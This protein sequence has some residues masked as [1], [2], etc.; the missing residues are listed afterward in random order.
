MPTIT[1]RG[2]GCSCEDLRGLGDCGDQ[3]STGD[4]AAYSDWQACINN[5]AGNASANAAYV[6]QVVKPVTCP[7]GFHWDGLSSLLS[8]GLGACIK[9]VPADPAIYGPV[10]GVMVTQS[11]WQKWQVDQTALQETLQAQQAAELAKTN[12]LATQYAQDQAARAQAATAA[13]VIVDTAAKQAAAATTLTN[14][15]GS[16][17]PGQIKTGSDGQ[18]Y[19]MQNGQWTTNLCQAANMHWVDDLSG[20]GACIA[21]STDSTVVQP[22]TY[23]GLPVWMLVVIALGG[24]VGLY[25]ISK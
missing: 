10:N 11:V 6:T 21:N 20:L 4:S 7:A 25:E 13:A 5:N 22:A 9:D 24:G 14:S 12:A 18:T 16:G 3:P 8:G 17:T 23:F 15:L 1:T 2:L 19:Q